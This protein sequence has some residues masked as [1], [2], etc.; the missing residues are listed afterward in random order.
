[1]NLIKNLLCSFLLIATTPVFSQYTY[2]LADSIKV[3]ENN[4]LLKNAWGGGFNA[5]QF[6]EI[7]LNGDNKT[8]LVVFLNLFLECL[9][10]RKI[11]GV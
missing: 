10:F 7:D 1:M 4:Q 11:L 5:P 3:Y 2:K 9:H 6:G 8:D